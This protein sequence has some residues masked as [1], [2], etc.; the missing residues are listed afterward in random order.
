MN[1]S[2]SD[3]RVSVFNDVNHFQKYETCRQQS[4]CYLLAPPPRPPTIPE[5][6]LTNACHLSTSSSPSVLANIR[7]RVDPSPNLTMISIILGLLIAMTSTCLILVLLG[8]R[9]VN[10]MVLTCCLLNG[11]IYH[12]RSFFFFVSLQI[13]IPSEITLSSSSNNRFVQ[14][15]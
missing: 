8:V 11:S 14:R 10:K 15:K 13:S 7:S 3:L 4:K 1:Q 12:R 9:F 6:F 2:L 5:L